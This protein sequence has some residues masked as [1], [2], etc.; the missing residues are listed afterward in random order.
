MVERARTA[1][2]TCADTGMK[3]RTVI[4]EIQA[5]EASGSR[6]SIGRWQLKSDPWGVTGSSMAEGVQDAV[7]AEDAPEQMEDQGLLVEPAAV[8]EGPAVRPK[9]WLLPPAVDVG[10]ETRQ[11]PAV[12]EA[13]EWWLSPTLQ[14]LDTGRQP[15]VGERDS[16]AAWRERRVTGDEEDEWSYSTAPGQYTLDVLRDRFGET[17]FLPKQGVPPQPP[18]GLSGF[19]LASPRLRVTAAQQKQGVQGGLNMGPTHA[20]RTTPVSLP[21][22]FGDLGRQSAVRGGPQGGQPAL[23]W[24][25]GMPWTPPP[26]G[27]TF[28]GDPDKLAM[29]LGHVLNHLDRFAAHYTSQWAIVVAMTAN[30]Q[31]EAATWAADLFGDH[32]SELADIGSFLE[33]LRVRFEDPT[34][35]Q[36]AEAEIV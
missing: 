36:R 2:C 11:R 16:Y 28:D 14:R 30:L 4:E 26:L 8:V 29:F 35:V 32:A 31:G 33:A 34:R 22:G 18:I 25:T 15:I 12:T 6:R 7:P 17:G 13:G 3:P 24:P 21:L 10:P 20:S 1:Q 5:A 27:I 19:R 9:E 23:V